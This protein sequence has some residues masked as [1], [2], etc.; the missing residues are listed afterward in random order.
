MRTGNCH[1]GSWARRTQ[2][3]TYDVPWMPTSSRDG[4]DRDRAGR[5]SWLL[6]IS[7]GNR[8][9]QAVLVCF[10]HRSSGFF[11]L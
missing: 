2:T 4:Q 5:Q 6:S 11:I 1:R 7:H 8:Q 10:L 9:T 3:T